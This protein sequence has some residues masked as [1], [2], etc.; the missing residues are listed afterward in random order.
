LDD[1]P[2]HRKW[3]AIPKKYN[4]QIH[5][6]YFHSGGVPPLGKTT[7]SS[8]YRMMHN[9][10]DIRIL[11]F[12]AS[13]KPSHVLFDMDPYTGWENVEDALE[14]QVQACTTNTEVN[15]V[16][17]H[18]IGETT[19]TKTT[20]AVIPAIAAVPNIMNHRARTP[21]GSPP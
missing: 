8:Y 7:Q 17:T 6:I 11:H 12:S 15:N 3:N 1:E 18:I 13:R 20:M 4:F 21:Q 19:H 9:M 16:W 10:K 14:C 2:R 5:Q